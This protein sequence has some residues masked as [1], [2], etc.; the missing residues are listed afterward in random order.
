M[1]PRW[2]SRAAKDDSGRTC[3][4]NDCG[5]GD[6][7][8][9]GGGDF[10]YAARGVWRVSGSGVRARILHRATRCKVVVKALDGYLD[11]VRTK[12]ADG[13][14]PVQ[15]LESGNA[16]SA[17]SAWDGLPLSPARQKASRK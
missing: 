2:K 3:S 10:G 7:V 15:E 6:S 5:P 16:C 14:H 11:A 1:Q 4:G 13:P 17:H 8:R 9:H 12:R